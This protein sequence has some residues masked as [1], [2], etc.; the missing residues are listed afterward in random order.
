M[1]VKH[2]WGDRRVIDHA[3]TFRYCARCPMIM[4]TR[5]EPDNFPITSWTEWQR[6]A[7]GVRFQ[8][9]RRP[10]CEPAS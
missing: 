1:A 2:S 4:V 5:H 8:S 7:D 6:G 3:T 9:A 10:V